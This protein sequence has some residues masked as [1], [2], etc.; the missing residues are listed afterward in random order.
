MTHSTA[1]ASAIM[2]TTVTISASHTGAPC[3]MRPT[4]VSAANSTMTPWEKL[5]T[6]EALKMSTNPS[7]TSEYMTPVK[8]PPITTSAKKIGK[9]AMSTNGATKKAWSTSILAVRSVC[10]GLFA[11][12]CLTPR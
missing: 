3:S 9:L 1:K 6:P 8:S 7:A 10:S 12:S 11:Q 4:R 5:N 2:T